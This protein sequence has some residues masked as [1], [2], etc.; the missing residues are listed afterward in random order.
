MKTPKPGTGTT[1][2]PN[3]TGIKHNVIRYKLTL[4]MELYM[5]PKNTEKALE[6]QLLGVVEDIYFRALKKNYIGYGNHMC[7][8][9]I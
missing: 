4:D 1:I 9:L 2:P 8:Q 3:A 7:L 6:Q 5:L